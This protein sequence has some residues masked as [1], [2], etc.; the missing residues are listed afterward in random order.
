MKGL[1]RMGVGLAAL[2]AVAGC[3][4]PRVATRVTEVPRVDLELAGGNRGYLIGTA[5][6]SADLKTTRQMMQTDIEVPSFYKAKPSGTPV[7]LGEFA[8]PERDAVG[9]AAAGGAFDSYTVQKGDSLWTIAAKP[10]VYGKASAWKR[11]LDANQDVLKGRPER[12]RPGMTLRIPRGGAG[13]GSGSDEG[14]TFTK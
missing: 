2:A 8:P 12:L 13:S 5:P 14:M 4:S 10:E 6:E 7:D 3:R 9:V 1:L 11:I